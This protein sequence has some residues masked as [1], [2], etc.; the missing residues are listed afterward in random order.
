MTTEN[1]ET[2]EELGLSENILKALT[3]MGF[4][5]PSPI[6]A[7]GIPAVMQGSD[8]IG[9]AQTGTGKTAAFGIP[10]LER[11][12]VSNNAVQAL[13]LCPTRELAV[14]VS[15]EIGR[16]AKYVKGL[17]IEAIYGGDSIDRQIRSLKKGVHIVVGTPGRVMDHMERKTL[18]FDEVRMMVLDEADEMLDMG[19]RED[20]ESIL[21][22]M[23][24]DR[25]TI[26]FSATMSKPIMSITKRFQ[27][28][29]ILI[30]VVRNELTNVNIEQVYF[31]VKPQAKVE[32]MTR[33]IDMHHLKSLLVFCNTK[34][35]VDEIVEDLQ[36]RGYA[37][38]GI[39]GDLRQQQRSNVMSKFKAGV[40]TILVATDV[41]ARGIDVSGLDGVINFDIPLDEEYYVHRIGR[42]GRAGLSGKA[43][44]LVA[45]DEKYRLKTIE[46][47]TKVKIEKGVIPSYEDIVGVRKA[48]FVESIS[49]SI[50]EG[51][52]Q[53]LF[54]DVLEMLHHA[55]YSTEQVVGAMAKQ[56]MG[57]QKNE[58]ADA[59]L[60]W[61]ERRGE[62]DGRRE[63]GSD[64][65][66]RRSSGGSRFGDR[67]ESAPRGNDRYAPAARGES[68]PRFEGG[69]DE[70][71][72]SATPEAG[73]T[74]LF[75]SLGR[76]DHIL[77]KD[78]VGAIAGEANIPGKTIGA[79]DIYDKFTFVD[80]PERDARAVLRAMDGNTIKGKPVQIDIAK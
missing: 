79:I 71:K 41:A 66:E 56:I 34:R 10:V 5:K 63:G 30:K 80:V 45:R 26:L 64:R 52:D 1:F 4:T 76:K 7:Q 59:N 69:R 44:S 15:E 18:K 12:D 51:D 53:E 72:R 17:R 25:Q 28:D 62:R 2:F 27:T 42:T 61:E 40:T 77:P 19:F 67:R 23:P 13:V 48:R 36:L 58:Y 60:A 22:D 49:A 21:A 74:R 14:Q 9:Q 6:Q 20:I 54:G 32:V 57:V 43:F 47:F 33:L 39:H 46:S 3:E 65:F 16:L 11:I 75:L 78:I 38:E 37:S 70:S 50:K 73:M 29:P 31:E 55:G 68:R 24:A 35:K 8:V